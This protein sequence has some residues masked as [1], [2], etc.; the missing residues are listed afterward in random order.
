MR[1]RLIE[2]AFVVNIGNLRNLDRID[3]GDNEIV[4]GANTKLKEI[5]RSPFINKRFKAIAEAAFQVGSPAITHMATLGGNILQ[6]TRCMYYNQSGIVLNGLDPCHKRG[7]NV[8]LAVKGGK[9]CFSVYQGDIAPALIAFDARCVLE[10]KGSTRTVPLTELFT[11]NGVAPIS[12]GVD[13]L[14]TK[15]IIPQPG[16]V[17]SSAYGKLR[18][19]GSVD[20][21]LA[22]A[23]AF[24][25]GQG[26]SKTAACRVV[27]SA[28]GAA[29]R[30]IDQASFGGDFESIAQ[31]AYELAEGA[32]TLQLPGAY[33]K[34]MAR[35]LTKRAIKAAMVD[36]KW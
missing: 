28:A 30:V 2:P 24:V 34:K 29:P 23:A 3:T 11:G 10:R 36:I 15:V 6:N 13:E 14:L 32:D 17:Y 1:L 9:R 19:R 35:V 33:R 8:C 5:A 25:S 12:I 31:R 27:I 20:Y 7:G 16:G 21:P 4:I 22:S 18:L 26:G